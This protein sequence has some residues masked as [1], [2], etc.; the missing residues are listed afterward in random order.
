MRFSGSIFAL[1]AV[2]GLAI[3]M[4]M[5]SI[6]TPSP[7]EL[8]IEPSLLR[9]SLTCQVNHPVRIPA[10]DKAGS[11][12]LGSAWRAANEKAIYKIAPETGI[13]IYRLTL[14]RT[15]REPIIVRLEE[16]PKGR[17]RITSSQ[18][19]GQ[20]GYPPWFLERQASRQLSRVEIADFKKDLA[21]A[22]LPSLQ[23]AICQ[24]GA[25]GETWTF[26][27]NE[28]GRY[29]FVRRWGVWNGPL[30]ELGDN[31]LRLTG[32]DLRPL[33]YSGKGPQ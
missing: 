25:D 21:A 4:I 8:Y 31:Y 20:G 11:N 7:G 1:Y 12:S 9:P 13:K 23:P 3:P 30:R 32:W 2:F 17:V 33:P 18:L 27:V 28:N 5:I 10:I 26:E 16:D 19:A 24:Y 22:K 14:L 29:V 15:F 6:F